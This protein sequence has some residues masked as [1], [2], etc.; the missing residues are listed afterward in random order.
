M[1]KKILKIFAVISVLFSL[2]IAGSAAYFHS[3]MAEQ[4]QKPFTQQTQVIRVKAG[5]TPYAAIKQIADIQESDLLGSDL[6]WLK[7]WLK[8]KPEF[9]QI[10]RGSYKIEAGDSLES[11]LTDFVAGKEFLYQITLIEGETYKQWLAR[12]KNSQLVQDDI[13]QA[14]LLKSWGSEHHYMEGLLM[15]ETYSY[16]LDDSV[17]D[18][19]KRS[20]QAMHK[21]IEELWDERAQGLPYKNPYEALIMASIVEKE[22]GV[23]FERPRIASVFVNRLR[24]G[25]KLQTDP[26]VIYG[27]G[28]EFDGDIRRKDLRAYTPYNTYVIN[29]LPPSP[30]AMA[31]LESLKAVLHPENTRY[32]YFVATGKNGEHYFS[33]TLKEH[34]RAVRKYILKR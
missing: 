2:L 28:D 27:M 9:T 34:N 11:I 19:L 31:S 6:R 15:P 10:K 33:K 5:Q 4:F 18:V 8:L 22:T 32:L 1:F 3:W 30:I 16:S 20:Y 21:A 7:L 14:E 29:G 13:D 12:L 26:T 25:M 17:S 24:K 23:A